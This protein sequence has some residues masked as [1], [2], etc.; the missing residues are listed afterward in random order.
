M[1]KIIHKIKTRPATGP[2]VIGIIGILL[3]TYSCELIR[4]VEDIKPFYKLTEE[5]TFTDATKTEAVL[6][7]VYTAWRGSNINYF[8]AQTML[9]SG[10]YQP[11]SAGQEE[12]DLF[13]NNVDVASSNLCYY[14]TE[15]YGLI[16]W[17]NFVIKAMQSDI[18][19]P[20]LS[21]IRRT[22]IEAEA[23]LHR[24]M[25]HF[26]LLRNFGQ[27]YDVSSELGIMLSN[28]PL[29]GPINTPRSG[30]QDCY[31]FILN[32]LDFA[33][34][35]AP[36]T[37]TVGR[38]SRHAA[39]AMK[40]KVLLYTKDWAG[41]AALALE[42]IN[43]GVYELK[44]DFRTLYAE[45]Y[46]SKEVI[47]SP[48]S[49]FPYGIDYSGSFTNLPGQSLKSA[50]DKS[51]GTSSD[52]NLTTG[53]GF[54]SRFVY[55]HI[56]SPLGVFNN[57]YPFPYVIDQQYNSQFILRLGEMYLVYAEAKARTATGIDSNALAKL[58]AI[59]KRAGL[60]DATPATK[61]ELLEAI[62]VEK[63]LELFGEFNEPWFDLVRYHILGDINI[64]NFK[65]TITNNNQLI[66]PYPTL[67][68]AG[69]GGLVQNP[70]Y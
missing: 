26:F 55:A 28:A 58:N 53:E 47:F 51:V 5:N 54:D 9:L 37:A 16:Q 20:G 67:A 21:A 66:L 56:T 11:S 1:K 61:A 22:E 18:E 10:N 40:A 24:V 34:A 39:K 41:A 27:F 14:Y 46:R 15:Y 23:R 29:G 35:N 4:P 6:N 25:A 42:T 70:G 62:R 33:M 50:A 36:A 52:G 7:G 68:L 69:N 31:D 12:S 45:G 44:T 59:R 30:V 19:I 3:L 49:I 8:T 43:S 60:P 48:I 64:S 63:Q 13:D 65:S 17:A 57:K 32:D 38:L 2:I